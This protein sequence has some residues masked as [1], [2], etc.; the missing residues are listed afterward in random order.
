MAQGDWRHLGSAGTK[1]PSPAGRSGL[2]SCRVGGNYGLDLIPGPGTPYVAGQPKK[3]YKIKN[4]L[5][6]RAESHIF[7]HSLIKPSI[8]VLIG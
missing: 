4:K 8:H 6:Y 1:V 7:I 5:R 3:K 2:S